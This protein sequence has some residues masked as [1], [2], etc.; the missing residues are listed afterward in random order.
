MLVEVAAFP[1]K[2]GFTGGGGEKPATGEVVDFP[3]L[4]FGVEFDVA[5][6]A[7]V[8]ATDLLEIDHLGIETRPGA[9]GGEVQ[10]VGGGNVHGLGMG[11]G[12]MGWV[13]SFKF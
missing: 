4:A 6:T 7:H 10:D 9:V 12:I 1:V 3:L 11:L 2:A 13:L 8:E 5:G